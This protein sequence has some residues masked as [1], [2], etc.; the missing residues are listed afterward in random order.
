M[1]AVEPFRWRRPLDYAELE[2]IRAMK[3]KID[4]T[5]SKDD[6][7]R[8]WGGIR[9]AEFFV[10]TFQ[11]LYGTENRS[12]RT[13]RLMNAIQGL[14]WL[15]LVPPQ[16]LSSLWENYLFLR[17]V[18]HLLQM[19][20]DVQTHSL[21]V[22]PGELAVLGKHLGFEDEK[23]FSSE[24][25]VRRRQV[26]TM[27]NSL[28]GTAEDVHAEA[29]ALLEG[30][31]S[32]AEASAYLAFRGVGE[33]GEGAEALTGLR[34]HLAAPRSGPERTAARHVLPVMLE[35]ALDTESPVRALRGIERFCTNLGMSEA[36]LSALSEEANLRKGMLKVFSLSTLLT[37]LLLSSPRY[38][39]ALVEDMPIRKSLRRM[40]DE[41]G[42]KVRD[43][44]DV[45]SALAFY[46]GAEELR[47]GM[48]FLSGILSEDVLARSLSHVADAVVRAAMRKAG[49]RGLSVL[50]LGKL[51]GRELTFGSDLDLIFVA[52]DD[53]GFKAAE[54]VIKLLSSYTPRGVPYRVDA[55]LRPDGTRGV[56]VND[57]DGYRQYYHGAARGWELQAL[58]KARPV[59]G[60]EVLSRDFL[61][62]SRGVLG[63]RGRGV[64][65]ADIS[66]MRRR[67]VAELAREDRG[68]DI[69]LG[70]GGL[71]EIEFHTQWL[72][73]RN[74]A[75][76]PRVLVQHTGTALGRLAACRALSRKRMKTLRETYDAHRRL[77]AFLRLN[78]EAV[79]PP[80]GP[81]AELAA[82]FM[83]EA[84]AAALVNRVRAR[85]ETV[86][87]TV[88][89][90]A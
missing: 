51:G 19:R 58:L 83:G 80:D 10:Q 2:D 64:R 6:I 16:E 68:M 5:L 31:L 54:R 55:R 29:L 60:D 44:G 42:R 22:D 57:I 84:D 81:L 24:L 15:G 61:R 37:S 74:A 41:L 18:E 45:S 21:P 53:E 25:R 89:A 50:G 17:R 46:R 30:D 12:L 28:L 65:R 33:S 77:H 90:R 14:R 72:Q 52:R 35:E 49:A 20:D 27:Y 78:D 62:M 11:L 48:L 34:E 36:Y 13:H 75:R 32:A 43:V 59:G 40:E 71:E 86:L 1:A 3:K 73:L 9:E 69:K 63:E 82:A 4:S 47:M 85:R 38:L 70:P 87:A 56:L 66:S 26:R 7:K 23:G 39:N 8:G 76:H 88:R 67:I 79:L